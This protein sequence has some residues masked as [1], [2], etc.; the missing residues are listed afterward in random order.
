[1]TCSPLGIVRTW[2]GGKLTS[3]AG[4]GRG[5]RSDG[6]STLWAGAIAGSV[7]A[8][9]EKTAARNGTFIVTAP[10]PIRPLA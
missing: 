9:S 2:Y 1:M 4:S 3:F 10:R 8:S 5:G 7:N 6:Q